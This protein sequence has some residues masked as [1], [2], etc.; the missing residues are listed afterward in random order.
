MQIERFSITYFV[1]VFINN[2][3]DDQI[4]GCLYQGF[5]NLSWRTPSPA[6]FVCLPHLTHLIPLISLLVET[7]RTKLG[8]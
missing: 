6:H 5:S 2:N 4:L 1:F 8:V 3:L 7:A